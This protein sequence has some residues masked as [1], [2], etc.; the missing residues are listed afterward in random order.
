MGNG[1]EVEFMIDEWPGLQPI[2][3]IEAGSEEIVQKYCDILGFDYSQAL[4][5]TIDQVYLQELGIEPEVINTMDEITFEN[6][7]KAQ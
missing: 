5:G 4:F 3:E 7:P 1:G 2:V 6:P